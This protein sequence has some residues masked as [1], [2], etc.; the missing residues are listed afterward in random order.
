MV[1]G[2]AMVVMMLARPEGLWPAARRRRE[3]RAEAE[4]AGGGE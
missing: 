4:T 1:F 3:L 2:A